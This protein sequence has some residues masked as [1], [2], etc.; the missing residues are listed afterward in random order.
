MSKKYDN[1]H[2][3][4]DCPLCGSSDVLTEKLLEDHKKD[5]SLFVPLVDVLEILDRY[6]FEDGMIDNNADEI[7]NLITNLVDP[8][9]DSKEEDGTEI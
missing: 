8:Q 1:E 2:F 3:I 4:Y 6:T 9:E 5:L 7:K